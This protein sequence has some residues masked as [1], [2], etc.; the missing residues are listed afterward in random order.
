MEL[1]LPTEFL[2]PGAA[3]QQAVTNTG[4][5]LEAQGFDPSDIDYA[6]S[7]EIEDDPRGDEENE[8][9]DHEE[10][11]RDGND[12][13]NGDSEL[14]IRSSRRSIQRHQRHKPLLIQ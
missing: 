5:L 9:S 11:D 10:A 4:N 13:K 14:K 6:L 3:N 12:A 7:G 2:S 8:N 1:D